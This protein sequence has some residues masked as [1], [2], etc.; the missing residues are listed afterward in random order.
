MSYRT[1][2]FSG[3]VLVSMANLPATNGDLNPSQNPSSA[4]PATRLSPPNQTQ[5]PFPALSQ[6]T[7]VVSRKSGRKRK[8]REFPE[9]SEPKK[10]TSPHKTWSE[11]DEV[12]LLTAAKEFR[13]RTGS[14]PRIATIREFFAEIKDSVARHLDQD[15]VYYK[16]KRLKSKFF[17]TGGVP[18]SGAHESVL[19]NLSKDVWHGVVGDENT[20]ADV[21]VGRVNCLI[22]FFFFG[23]R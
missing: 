21:D 11:A 12:V 4:F 9:M 14:E 6:P 10:L 19:Y 1:N 5:S 20:H 18:P 16:L 17:L 3:F 13:A 15:K 8:I 7:P 2:S 23:L 22:I